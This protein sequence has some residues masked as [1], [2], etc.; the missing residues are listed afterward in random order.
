MSTVHYG[1]FWSRIRN[2]YPIAED[3][4]PLGEP[5][6]AAGEPRLEVEFVQLP[7]L[8]RVFLIHTDNTYL[9]QV[10]P[11]ALFHNWRKV[12]EEDQYPHFEQAKDRFY[13]ALAAFRNFAE[14]YDL[15]PLTT[16]HYEVT[17]IN[18][19][20]EP[21]GSFPVMTER[22]T[23][24]FCW[25]AAQSARVLPAPKS[26]SMTLTFAVPQERGTLLVSWKQGIRR[27]TG[28]AALQLELTAR[29]RA[30]A[31]A[32]DMDNWLELAHESIVRG[33][34]DLTS[35]WAHQRWERIQ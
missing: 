1:A 31:D 10:Q 3:K 28:L 30:S 32:S 25:S 11:D 20:L 18:H 13:K 27:D 5:Q 16:T 2:E 29:G 4:P 7:P 12:K 33:F 34:A 8:R 26:L 9:M 24:V 21:P 19:I 22:Y 15:G 14:D 6:M 23:P 35:P 17:Y